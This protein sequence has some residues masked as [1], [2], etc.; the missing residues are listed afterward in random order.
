LFTATDD[1]SFIP[2]ATNEVYLQTDLPLQMIF[3]YK[4]NCG[5]ERYLFPHGTFLQSPTC[6]TYW[7]CIC[8]CAHR[9]RISEPHPFNYRVL[10]TL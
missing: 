1:V 10:G 5:H 2:A 3:V 6:I 8:F 9:R 7:N 4:Q